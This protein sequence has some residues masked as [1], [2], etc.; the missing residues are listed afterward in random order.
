M[1]C[2][3]RQAQ[4]SYVAERGSP[5]FNYEKQFGGVIYVFLR[6]VR[7][8]GNTGFYTTKPNRDD[9]DILDIALQQ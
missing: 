4:P 2:E 6:G 3:E 7:E 5:D 9:I 1:A 8:D